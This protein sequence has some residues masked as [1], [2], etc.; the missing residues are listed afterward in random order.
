MFTALD[1]SPKPLGTS[2]I[3]KPTASTRANRVD[4]CG[5]PAGLSA[6]SIDFTFTSVICAKAFLVSFLLR[7]ASSMALM[8][9]SLFKKIAF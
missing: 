5:L 7:R 1:S 3:S 4:I 9:E 6:L 8:R 2:S